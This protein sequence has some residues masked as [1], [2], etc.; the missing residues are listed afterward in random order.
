MEQTLIQKYSTALV[1]SLIEKIESL[2]DLDHKLAK[3]ELRELFVADILKQFL[4]SQFDIGSGIVINQ[5]G[6]QSRQTDIIIYDRR[7]LPPFIKEQ[8]LGVFPAESVLATIE[9]KSDLRKSDLLKAEDSAKIM[10]EVIYNPSS[11][12]YKDYNIFRPICAT[13]GFYGS[14]IKELNDKIKGKTWLNKNI[15]NLKYVGLIN[16]YSWIKMNQTGWTGHMVD[17]TNH[18]TK[19]FI[20]VLLDNVRTHA[21]VRLR[22]LSERH[23]DWLG[24]YIREQKLFG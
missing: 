14:G 18:E 8:H 12:L 10:L 2:S 22:L 16:R 13:F 4:T 7:I 3:G 24:I 11:S 15:E 5:K 17:K 9:I 1:R 21:E 23:N 6:E 19:R 20:A